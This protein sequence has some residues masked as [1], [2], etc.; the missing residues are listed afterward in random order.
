[1]DIPMSMIKHYQISAESELDSMPFEEGSLY[2]TEDTKRIYLDPAGGSSRILVNGD[3]IILSTESERK[4]LLA[5]LYSKIYFVLETSNIYIYRD[6]AW[7]NTIRNKEYYCTLSASNWGTEFPY[8]QSITVNGILASDV[9]IADVNLSDE[10][11]DVVEVLNAWGAIARIKT[12]NNGIVAYCYSDV[13]TLD[14]P[15]I[16]KVIN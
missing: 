15:I 5:P 2:F 1:M 4:N 16:L 10:S 14:I 3:P 9:P 7:Y 12:I 8:T 6:G 13:P 11:L